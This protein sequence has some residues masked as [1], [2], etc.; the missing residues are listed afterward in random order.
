MKMN[1]KVVGL[2]RQKATNLVYRGKC[3]NHEIING[4]YCF[5][6]T[7]GGVSVF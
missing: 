5:F 4:G 7:R 6:Q 2:H 1:G 3:L